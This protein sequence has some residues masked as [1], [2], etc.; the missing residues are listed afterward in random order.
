MT[1]EAEHCLQNGM[2]DYLSKPFSIE[3]I[4]EMLLRWSGKNRAA[5]A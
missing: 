4:R 1:G 2:D 5:S 3:K